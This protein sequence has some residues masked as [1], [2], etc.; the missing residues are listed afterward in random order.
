MFPLMG[1]TIKIQFYLYPVHCIFSLSE[2]FTDLE[3]RPDQDPSLQWDFYSSSVFGR[4]LHKCVIQNLVNNLSF[5]QINLVSFFWSSG[6]VR[7]Q[8]WFCL[9][10]WNNFYWIGWPIGGVLAHSTHRDM[11]SCHSV[12]ISEYFLEK[13]QEACWDFLLS[14]PEEEGKEEWRDQGKEKDIDC[15]LFEFSSEPLLPCYHVQVSLTQGWV[16]KAPDFNT[17]MHA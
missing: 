8:E 12:Y 15:L 9:C 5:H 1:W 2:Y 14:Q 7:T 11:L 6:Q 10:L 16:T 3:G 4:K 17:V 13:D